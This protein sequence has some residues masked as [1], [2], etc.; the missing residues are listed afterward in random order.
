MEAGDYLE[1]D[2]RP[3]EQ[4]A[5]RILVLIAVVQRALIEATT[6]TEVEEA[7]FDLQATLMLSG[8]AQEQTPA[9]KA[10]ISSP[11]GKTSED[12]RYA[13][14]WDIEALSAILEATSL[15]ESLPP[16]PE[17]SDVASVASLFEDQELNVAKLIAAMEIPDDESAATRR[18]IAELWHWRAL[19]EQER[20]N[21]PRQDK[22][23]LQAEI[24]EVAYEAAE[25]GLI[26][27]S[28]SG[29]FKTEDQPIEEWSDD[30]LV[31]FELAAESR[32]RALN[33]LCGFGTTWDDVPLEI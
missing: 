17:L 13:F 23:Q 18:E 32:L 12:D 22:A 7:L 33:W 3:A 28:K 10:F 25:A 30:D 5:R 6:D 31:G 14:A 21:A 1:I 16:P 11:G 2:V 24:H 15:R 4:I 29:D 8:A 27:L 26:G 20:R 9:E 19:A